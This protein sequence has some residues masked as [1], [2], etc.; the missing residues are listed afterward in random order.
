MANPETEE[1][2][3]YTTRITAAT[4]AG[5]MQWESANPSTLTWR[6]TEGGRIVL[7]RVDKPTPTGLPVGFSPPKAHVL[8]VIEG[9]EDVRLIIDGR[10]D[11]LLDQKLGLLFKIARTNITKRGLDYLNKILPP[12]T[13]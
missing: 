12:G 2:V 4:Q 13:D 11:S 5:E 8:Q 6:S 3:K 10:R 1:F 9:Q 7:Q